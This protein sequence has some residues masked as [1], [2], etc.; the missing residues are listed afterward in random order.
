M[1]ESSSSIV[2][3]KGS[4]SIQHGSSV[5]SRLENNST[6]KCLEDHSSW[7]FRNRTK[8]EFT[9]DLSVNCSTIKDVCCDKVRINSSS[10]ETGNST[11][12]NLT[13]SFGVYTA[14]GT[15]NGRY[16]Y[17]MDGQDIFLEFGG[18]YQSYWMVTA[19]IGQTR[20]YGYT[21][22]RYDGGS[23]CPEHV[24][25]GWKI[26]NVTTSFFNS[27]TYVSSW[28]EEPGITVTCEGKDQVRNQSY[29]LIK[30]C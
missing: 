22:I 26:P 10:G 11:Y 8:M 19:G 1:E 5:W 24:S 15:R 21:G 30:I 18:S 28:K 7:S 27:Y 14:I 6:S 17:Q 9:E 13:N 23:I 2:R 4:G 16:I 25:S 20:V 3:R 12:G 29:N